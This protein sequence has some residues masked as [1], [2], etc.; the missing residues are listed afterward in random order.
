MASRM[1]LIGC[2]VVAVA[3]L[4]CAAATEYQVG[5][6]LGWAVP[7]NTSYYSTWASTKTFYLGDKF[8]FSWTG[9]QNAAPVSKADYENCT[10]VSSYIGSPFL[11][12]P[13]S[14]GSYYFICVVDN[15]CEQ[16]QK[17]ALTVLAPSS[18]VE[19]PAESPES[20]ASS[21]LTAGALFA[22]LSTAVVSV[23]TFV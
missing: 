5:D 10:Q 2:L 3:L 21:Q 23:L 19:E 4:K 18:S 17:V 9:T 15:N 8:N 14:A 6:S 20:S 11:F 7:P 22:A 1:G 12:T 13:P 16:G